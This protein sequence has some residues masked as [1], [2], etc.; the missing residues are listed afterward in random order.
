VKIFFKIDDLGTM[1]QGVEAITEMNLFSLIPLIRETMKILSLQK[2]NYCLMRVRFHF[3]Q[4]TSHCYSILIQ[5]QQPF[6]AK[7]AQAI[8]NN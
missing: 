3:F 6:M 4:S 1:V 7:L 2:H 8:K 5:S